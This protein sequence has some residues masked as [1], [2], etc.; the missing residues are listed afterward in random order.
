MFLQISSKFQIHVCC[1][2]QQTTLSKIQ[3]DQMCYCSKLYFG[4]FWAKGCTIMQERLYLLPNLAHT[5]S[6][7]P[8]QQ[9]FKTHQFKK[10]THHEL[11]FSPLSEHTRYN[12]KVVDFG[13]QFLL[14]GLALECR[15]SIR[16]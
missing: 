5:S 15:L 8:P 2:A 7:G 14:A 10:L 13:D 1:Q 9:N 16:L 3:N 11:S 4:V 12:L 6:K